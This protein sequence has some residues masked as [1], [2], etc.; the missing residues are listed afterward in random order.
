M[1]R[2]GVAAAPYRFNNAHEVVLC[3]NPTFINNHLIKSKQSIVT[4]TENELY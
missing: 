2:F 4:T 1:P 3:K